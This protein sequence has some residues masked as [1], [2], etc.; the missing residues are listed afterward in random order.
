MRKTL[1]TGMMD[2]QVL[3]QSHI[4]KIGPERLE[5]KSL[6]AAVPT[7]RKNAG[8]PIRTVFLSFN[9]YFNR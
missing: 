9:C 6:G 7:P 3:A 5:K 4:Q 8:I 1:I 2:Q